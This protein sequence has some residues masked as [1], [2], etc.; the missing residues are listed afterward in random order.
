VPASKKEIMDYSVSPGGFGV[1]WNKVDEG[2]SSY[3]M[4]NHN[5][6]LNTLSQ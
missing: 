1:S 3:G 5:R 4:L 6:D 2:L